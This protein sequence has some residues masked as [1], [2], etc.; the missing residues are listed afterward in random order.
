TLSRYAF[1]PVRPEGTIAMPAGRAFV[2]A[3]SGVAAAK[4]GN[5]LAAYNEASS[6]A[7]ALLAVWNEAIRSETRS[8]AAALESRPDAYAVLRDAIPRSGAGGFTAARLLPRLE[9]FDAESRQIIPAACAALQA[10]D[11]ARFG[12]L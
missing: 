7:Q 12:S 6:S 5:A 9:H 10:G 3:F 4:S 2:V 11:L 1:C 8:L